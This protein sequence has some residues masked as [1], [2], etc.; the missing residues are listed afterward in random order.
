MKCHTPCMIHGCKRD[1]F[2]PVDNRQDKANPG[3]FKQEYPST[4]TIKVE[5]CKILKGR[6]GTKEK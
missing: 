5:K 1:H 6:N 3:S 4:I 2:N